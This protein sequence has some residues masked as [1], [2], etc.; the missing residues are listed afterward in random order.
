MKAARSQDLQQA[1]IL[2]VIE[3]ESAAWYAG[4]AEAFAARVRPDVVFTNIVGR[5]SVGKTPFVAQH[6]HIFSTIYKN[7][8]LQMSLAQLT[9]VRPDVAIVDS[10]CAL[11]GYT[12]APPGIEAAD[13]VIRTRLEQVMVQDGGWWVASFHNVAVN[14][15]LAAAAL[16]IGR[17]TRKRGPGL[18]AGPVTPEACC[19]RRRRR[20]LARCAR[21]PQTAFFVQGGE[22]ARG[23]GGRTRRG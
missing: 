1:S 11:S 15:T 6:A 10:I 19:A 3:A 23:L 4:D 22:V 14:P 13:G 21:R 5:F 17:G 12:K 16:T 7:S 8:R 18:C 9:F 20:A 2:A